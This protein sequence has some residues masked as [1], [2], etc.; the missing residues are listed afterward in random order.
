MAETYELFTGDKTLLF[1]RFRRCL[2]GSAR[3]DWYIIVNGITLDKATLQTSL[4][5]LLVEIVGEDVEDNLADNMERT[6]KP[7]ALKF[8]HWIRRIRHMNI[9]LGQIAE[10]TKKYPDKIIIRNVIAPNISSS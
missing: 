9:Y 5:E 4:K 8:R 6:T 2:K 1:D 3:A 7:R 10:A